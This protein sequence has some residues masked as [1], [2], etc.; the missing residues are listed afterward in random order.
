MC[1][2]RVLI[3]KVLLPELMVSGTSCVLERMMVASSLLLL[4]IIFYFDHLDT[5]NTFGIWCRSPLSEI[6]VEELTYNKDILDPF[7]QVHISLIA[8]FTLSHMRV[9]M[10]L[11]PCIICGRGTGQ[12][13]LFSSASIFYEGTFAGF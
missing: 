7:L 1:P 12:G 3:S 11:F 9:Y 8:I 2:S 5:K 10:F 4:C 6:I 13:V